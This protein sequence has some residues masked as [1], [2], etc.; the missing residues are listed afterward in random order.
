MD[1]V[2]R[3]GEQQSC[4][5]RGHERQQAY[6]PQRPPR[7]EQEPDGERKVPGSDLVRDVEIGAP[8]SLPK[9]RP[10]VASASWPAAT[11]TSPSRSAAAPARIG[12]R[13]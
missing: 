4:R 5:Q 8:S 9:S 12:R 11:A 13:S 1:D 3:R 10:G 2:D 7:R 6:C